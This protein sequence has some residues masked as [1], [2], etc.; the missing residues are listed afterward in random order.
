MCSD[1]IDVCSERSANSEGNELPEVRLIM[2]LSELER[3]KGTY[4]A[5]HDLSVF[6]RALSSVCSL[7][8]YLAPVWV[9]LRLL[10]MIA[11]ISL[12]RRFCYWCVLS[13]RVVGAPLMALLI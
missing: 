13:V 9:P 11:R 8:H 12:R 7:L 3:I 4:K 2:R 6:S 10:N 1:A 5:P